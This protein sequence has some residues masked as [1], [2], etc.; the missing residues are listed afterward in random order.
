VGGRALG[1]V[2]S[3]LKMPPVEPALLCRN[4]L[5]MTAL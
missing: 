4:E 1:R 3:D 5:S 2:L